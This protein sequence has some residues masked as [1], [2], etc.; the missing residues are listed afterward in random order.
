MLFT[1]NS[2]PSGAI[3]EQSSSLARV[4]TAGQ[5]WSPPAHVVTAAQTDGAVP[6]QTKQCS[7]WQYGSQPS[8]RLRLPSS[9]LSQTVFRI[10]SPQRK[11]TSF[12]QVDEHPSQLRVFPSSHCSPAVTIRLPQPVGVQFESQP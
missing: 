2:A 3:G 4:Q 5:H 9:Q 7:I 12:W 1:W 6:A 10:P 11:P 8:P